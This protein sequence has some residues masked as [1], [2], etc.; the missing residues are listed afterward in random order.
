MSGVSIGLICV[1]LM[2]YL[3]GRIIQDLVHILIVHPKS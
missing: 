3:R 1:V 2:V